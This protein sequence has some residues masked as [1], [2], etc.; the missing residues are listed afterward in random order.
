[1]QGEREFASSR[2]IAFNAG[3]RSVGE[4][5]AKVASVVF[6]IAIAR[7][8]GQAS[9]GDFIFGMSLCGVL[10][11]LAAFGTDELLQR[12]IARDHAKVEEM[13]ANVL[14]LRTGLLVVLGAVV[15]AIVTV[16]GY[17]L[18]T[19]LAVMLIGV[20]TGIE[21]L[22]SSIYHVLQGYER[23]AYVSVTLIVQR[24]ST[25]ALGIAVLAL[26][27]GLVDVAIA[28]AVGSVFGL[29]TS[30][31]L[32]RS[33]VVAPRMRIDRSRW[34]ALIKAGV[35]LGLV[36]LLFTT[37]LKLDVALL[38]FLGGEDNE[39]VGAY[40]AAYRLVEA[41]MFLSWAWSTAVLPWLSR[42]EE[43]GA[44]SLARGFE[45]G[46]KG[47]SA[48][49]IPIGVV[50]GI[51]AEPLIHLFYG[52]GYDDAI[53]PLR[54]LAGMT[55][56]YGVNTY[57]AT[58]LISR[59]Q[60]L[61]FARSAA[62]LIVQNVVFNII[63]IPTYGAEGAA[64]N[65]VLSGLLLAVL[66]LRAADRVAGPASF[67]RAF[68]APVLSGA[69]MVGTIF[70]LGIG[71][72]SAAVGAVVYCAAFAGIERVAAPRDF[73]FYKGMLRAASRKG[74]TIGPPPGEVGGVS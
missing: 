21:L 23:M 15:Y 5:V 31:Y 13:L 29:A 50:Y 28:F 9:F 6:F 41:T 33:R 10:F 17:D 1:M 27:G 54:L 68:A 20:G 3:I 59:D 7:E 16:A 69:L 26:G 57:A 44:V 4:I 12:E 19:R 67:G 61:A 22:T 39:E 14:V 32:L 48:I 40:G 52:S 70:A 58:V 47:I 35:P 64:F 53:A 45:L 62:I 42:H 60:P 25:A 55:V 65:A 38:S 34:L 56:L 24:T 66:S 2:R 37:L 18:D 74:G 63:L 46:L 36:L 72:A 49:L 73:E 43:G 11:M 71:F 30:V 51:L 8:L